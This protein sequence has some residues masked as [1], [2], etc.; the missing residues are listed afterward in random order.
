MSN[1]Q[2]DNNNN[3]ILR[4]KIKTL[5][6]Y[7]HTV[8]GES[9]F[10]MYV[11][12]PRLSD[13]VDML[14]VTISERLNANLKI[15][16]EIGVVGQFRSYNKLEDGKS[17][18]ML[19][20]F[21]KEIVD[22]DEVN[23]ANQIYLV[24]YICKEPVFRTTPFGREISDM[25]LAV[26]R[27]YNKSDYLP[28][29]AWGRNAK[30]VKDLGV[31]EKLEVQ[32]RI[33]SR[34]YQKHISDTVTET[35]IAYEISLSSVMIARE[36]TEDEYAEETEDEEVSNSKNSVSSTADSIKPIDG[37]IGAVI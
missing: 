1:N 28:C 5:P 34:K 25:L 2:Y 10:E 30:F 18:L 22:P 36:R 9:F 12:V 33:Q 17:K 21:A 27:A 32:G 6:V 13:E 19:T 16:D 29:I 14:P 37:S 20:I 15:G 24:G 8:M 4:G 7:S 31:G 35:K 26:N 11:E 23:Q 3:V